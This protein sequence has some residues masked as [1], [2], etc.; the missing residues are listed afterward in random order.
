MNVLKVVLPVFV[1][2]AAGVLCRRT[3]FLSQKGIDDLKKLL[4]TVILPVAIFEGM[5]TGDYSGKTGLVVAAMFG[6]V[7][8]TFVLGFV[9][10]R[11][12][13]EPYRKYFPFLMS[14]YE[15]GMIAYPLF[16]NLCGSD[17]LS[18]IA[19]LDI[20]GCAFCFSVYIN[21]LVQMESG[22]KATVKGTL[23]SAFKN[24]VFI[25]TLLGVFCGATGIIK[26]LLKSPA[27]S[28]YL[29]VES[30]FT[31]ALSAMILLVVGYSFSLEKRLIGPCMKA[32][33]SRAG[34]QALCA[35]PMVPLVRRL[36]P[37][38]RV[39]LAAVCLY[40]AA[41][42]SFSI[43]SFVKDEEGARYM[44]TSNSLYVIVT[45]IVYTCLAAFVV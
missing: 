17:A 23:V 27:G 24:P 8:V 11:L 35:V 32:I 44:A 9:L 21:V 13:K 41:P 31:A 38:D 39:M 19:V 5:A 45:I 2:I 16:I 20:A 14:V 29:S 43:P 3:Q 4:T 1:M 6:V 37:D 15:G 36:F 12:V 42:P 10:N 25:G 26:R 40:L 30:M 33:L 7:V 18:K 28:V 34:L 22:Q